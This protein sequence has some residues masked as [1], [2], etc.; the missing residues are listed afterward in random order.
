MANDRLA[1]CK[2]P[3]KHQHVHHNN[4]STSS[5]LSSRQWKKNIRG[6]KMD[7]VPSNANAFNGSDRN[8]QENIPNLI[9]STTSYSDQD[10]LDTKRNAELTSLSPVA[11]VTASLLLDADELWKRR[12]DGDNCSIV[13]LRFTITE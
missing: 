3:I 8:N 2:H 10:I 13:M 9:G 7:V 11:V 6:K 12:N 4:E 1:Q 5:S